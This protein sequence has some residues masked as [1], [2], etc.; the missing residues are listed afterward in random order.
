MKKDAKHKQLTAKAKDK[1]LYF[2]IDDLI[3]KNDANPL[4]SHISVTAED[5]THWVRLTLDISPL[6]RH[7]E[8][9]ETP[10]PPEP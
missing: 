4:P 8:K 1:L 9:V 5:K 10:P 7:D 2:L 6:R 3:G